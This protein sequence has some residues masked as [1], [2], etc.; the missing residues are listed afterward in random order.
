MYPTELDQMV[1]SECGHIR[2]CLESYLPMFFPALT[3]FILI[4]R[5]GP[6]GATAEDL[7]EIKSAKAEGLY[8]KY[9]VQA[10]NI[11]PYHQQLIDEVEEAFEISWAHG[12]LQGVQLTFM[13]LE[14]WED[15]RRSEPSGGNVLDS[16][17]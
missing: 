1:D 15:N 9:D 4:L 12:R 2:C 6:L 5:P 11:H 16:Q 7:Y 13:R 17:E 10:G 8:V 3:E 14:K